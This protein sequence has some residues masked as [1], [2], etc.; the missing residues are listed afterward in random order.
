MLSEVEMYEGT[1]LRFVQV[2]DDYEG[3]F[4][5]G[6]K[7]ITDAPHLDYGIRIVDHIVSNT[8]DMRKNCDNL[9]KWIGLHT[10]AAFSKEVR[11]S[12]FLSLF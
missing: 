12:N 10:F 9:I 8:F 3:V 1:T 6:Y 5:P 2:S 7:A 11:N 4:L